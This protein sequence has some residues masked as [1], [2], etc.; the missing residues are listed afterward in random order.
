MML[1]EW[2]LPLT[3]ASGLTD[4]VVRFLLCCLANVPLGFVFY[5]LLVRNA[6]MPR[7]LVHIVSIGIG[8]FQLV[9][10]FGP[11]GWVHLFLSS[12]VAMLFMHFL[13]KTLGVRLTWL[14]AIGYLSYLHIDRML[15]DYGGYKLDVSGPQMVVTIKLTA[16]AWNILDGHL[17]SK[18]NSYQ[19]AHCI[20][21]ED[22]PSPLQFYG[23]VFY[24]PSLLLGPGIEFMDY[25]RL[26][27]SVELNTPLPSFY[28]CSLIFIL[29]TS[30]FHFVH[31]FFSFFFFQMLMVAT[32]KKFF[33][34]VV[35][36]P[37]VF[38]QP[39]FSPTL[40]DSLSWTSLPLWRKLFD[41]YLSS[42]LLRTKYYFAWSLSDLGFTAAG[43]SYQHNPQN[44]SEP[45][46][47]AVKNVDILSIEYPADFSVV[48]AK[49]N[50]LTHYWLKNHVFFR[51]P[52]GSPFGAPLTF[53][54]SA[55]WHGFY[56]SYYF[57]FATF[58]LVD[59]ID[60]AFTASVISRFRQRTDPLS[61]LLCAAH[62]LLIAWLTSYTGIIFSKL[63]PQEVFS[64]LRS[65]TFFGHLLLIP[66]LLLAL[67]FKPKCDPSPSTA[68]STMATSTTPGTNANPSVP[69][70]KKIA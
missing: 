16:Y 56:P 2:T 47:D 67:L 43:S 15:E 13:P 20:K 33:Q 46:W 58:F 55:F 35:L 17:S 65:V 39:M 50:I 18:L 6:A 21:P 11:Y 60:K 70:S 14:W 52:R 34:V 38:L 8:V 51:L 3:A 41:V 31:L 1:E 61:R 48:P 10:C 36:L 57:A 49:W 37:F 53:L 64:F 28:V 32:L 40:F 12:T 68:T 23:F 26:I 63:S 42:V 66:M 5:T 4:D 62:S 44:P 22:S 29:H 69:T 30:K 54:V 7:N 45:G 24:F 27:N 9:F 25:L 59:F 19:A